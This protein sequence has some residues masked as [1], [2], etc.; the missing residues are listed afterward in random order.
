MII[1]LYLYSLSKFY[2]CFK[3]ANEAKYQYICEKHEKMVLKI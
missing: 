2:L 3:D 1:A